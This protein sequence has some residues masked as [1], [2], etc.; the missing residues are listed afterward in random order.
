M[1][2]NNTGFLDGLRALAAFSVL[3]CHCMIW[4]GW[5]G[6]G[7]PLLPGPGMLAKMAVDLFMII[8]GFLMAYNAEAPRKSRANGSPGNVAKILHPTR[9]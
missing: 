1:Q 2:N 4:S 8:S 5:P 6:S 9:L 7:I 3:T